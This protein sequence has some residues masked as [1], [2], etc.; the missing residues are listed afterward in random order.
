[1]SNEIKVK[2]R[3]IGELQIIGKSNMNKRE[4]VGVEVSE[5]D[6]KYE[7]ILK[8][9]LMNKNVA[10]IDKCAV[11]DIVNVHYDVRGRQWKEHI[12]IDLQAWKIDE[13]ATA[14]DTDEVNEQPREI[15]PSTT[16]DDLDNLPF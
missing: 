12:F 6:S 1:M 8:F 11:G 9:T 7:N 2:I 15:P 5:R 4:F 13:I 16:G 10:K 14:S 3:E